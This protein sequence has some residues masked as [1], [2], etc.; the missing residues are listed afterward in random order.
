VGGTIEIVPTIKPPT[1]T[2]KT[3]NWTSNNKLIATVNS[4]GEIR[5]VKRGST[6]VLATA[7]AYGATIKVVVK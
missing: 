6:S 3:V 1:A 4:L 7:G 2:N 5:G